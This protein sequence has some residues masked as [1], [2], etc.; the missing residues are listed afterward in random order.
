MKEPVQLND[1]IAESFFSVIITTYNRADL[2]KRALNSLLAQTEPDWE[3]V[4]I[5]DGSTDNTESAIKP[6]LEN[7]SRFKYFY[8]E[9]TGYSLAKNSGIF[10]AKGKFV[11]FLDSDDEYFPRHLET[12]KAILAE[13]PE[14]QFLYGGIT[15]TGNQLVPDRFDNK[16]LIP[17]SE[18]VIGGTFFVRR[19]LAISL[20]GFYDIPMGSDADF[21]ERVNMTPVTVR[22]TFIP[23]YLYHREDENSLTNILMKKEGFSDINK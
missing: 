17:L 9:N 3:A 15:I 1:K 16:K 4:I 11:T 10:L 20:N 13:H 7:E 23:T 8:Q 14:T 5:D 18:C 19:P 21:F 22:E 2:L 6:Y 12:R